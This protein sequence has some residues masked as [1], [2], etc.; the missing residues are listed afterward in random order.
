MMT[1][2]KSILPER[3]KAWVIC[4][5][6]R[7]ADQSPKIEALLAECPG[8]EF[9]P[10]SSYDERKEI[11]RISGKIV[12]TMNITQSAIGDNR[13]LWVTVVACAVLV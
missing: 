8:V 5:R 3:L 4:Q 1:A 12:K 7:L 6:D 9:D 10:N 13:K 2:L 11:W